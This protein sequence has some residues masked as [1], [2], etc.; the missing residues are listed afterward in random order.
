MP[1][2]EVKSAVRSVENKG[3]SVWFSMLCRE[4]RFDFFVTFKEVFL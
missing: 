4:A 3:F 2:K 1:F